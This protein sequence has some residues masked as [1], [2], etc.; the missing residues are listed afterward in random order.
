MEVELAFS[1]ERKEV[2][3]LAEFLHVYG[4]KSF[5]VAISYI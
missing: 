1:T 4:Q 2:S 5:H 3:C